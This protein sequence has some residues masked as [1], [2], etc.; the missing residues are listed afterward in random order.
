MEGLRHIL[1][2]FQIL[3]ISY[4]SLDFHIYVL[5]IEEQEYSILELGSNPG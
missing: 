4:S 1:Y 2:D 3:T 5:V